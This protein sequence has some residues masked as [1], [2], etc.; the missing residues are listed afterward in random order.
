MAT[1][2][3]GALDIAFGSSEVATVATFSRH[4]NTNVME[5]SDPTQRVQTPDYPKVRGRKGSGKATRE[6]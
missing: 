1:L 5:E 6:P 4:Q 3:C 2:S